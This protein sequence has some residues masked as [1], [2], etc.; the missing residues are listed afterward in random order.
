MPSTHAAH[1]H[2]HAAEGHADQGGMNHYA[3]LLLMTGLSFVAMYLL[4]Y[5]MVDS[6][7]GYFNNVN[8]AYMAGLM[9]AA[10]V[11]I[12][13]GVM[14]AMYPSKTTNV[15][16]MIVSL[17]ALAACWGLIRTQAGVGDRQFLRSMIPHHS[18]ALL[19]CR[20]AP[21]GDSEIRKLCAGIV[22]SQQREIEQMKDI[23]ARL[24]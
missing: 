24:E 19:M 15:A 8:Q 4:M 5:A 3:R 16:L 6:F 18:G 17:V 22:E 21:I 9:A 12:E 2:Q 20:E 11:V 1:R 14:G 23:L 7:D 10:M 13:L